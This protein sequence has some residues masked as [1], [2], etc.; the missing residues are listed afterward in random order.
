MSNWHEWP[1]ALVRDLDEAGYKLVKRY[2]DRR[3]GG[4]VRH[5]LV[6][7]PQT[8]PYRVRPE[9]GS[10]DVDLVTGIVQSYYPEAE[11]SSRG[12]WLEYTWLVPSKKEE[13]VE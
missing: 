10:V 12:G 1:K 8:S 6:I 4:M 7:A 5:K 13:E 2:A 3:S 9:E 11:P